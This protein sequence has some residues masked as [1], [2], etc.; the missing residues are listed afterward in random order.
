MV[1]DSTTPLLFESMTESKPN[2]FQNALQCALRRCN[3]AA[4][5]FTHGEW[6]CAHHAL[7]FVQIRRLLNA[8]TGG[9]R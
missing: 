6:F 8:I 2:P 3:A 7:V 9:A 5:V 1:T 4:L